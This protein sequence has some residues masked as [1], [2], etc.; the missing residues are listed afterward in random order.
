[1]TITWF[2]DD[3]S[4]VFLY[5]GL[6]C[7]EAASSFLDVCSASIL[8]SINGVLAITCS[9]ILYDIIIH[10]K[11]TL[12]D[13]KAT[14]HAVVLS[15][16][17]LHWFFTFLYYTDVASVT[18]VLAM[19]LASLKK[20]YWLSALVGA[21]AVVVRQTNIIWVLFVACIG[22]IDISLMRGKGNARTIKSDVSVEHD[23]TYVT[24]RSAKGLNLKRRKSVK[25]VNTSEYSLPRISASS[26]SFSSGLLE[27]RK[28]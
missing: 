3:C 27:N 14:L 9:I 4:A 25:T 18:A 26:P 8:R 17:P 11:P 16:Y 5:H 22:I 28:E 15:L 6:Y 24:G 12:G 21:F 1:M 10:L 13:R 19:Y 2:G 20:N 23:F 7:V